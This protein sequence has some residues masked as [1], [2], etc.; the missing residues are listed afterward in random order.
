M[1][2]SSRYAATSSASLLDPAEQTHARRPGTQPPTTPDQALLQLRR[3]LVELDPRQAT[4][5]RKF[6]GVIPFGD[7]VADYLRSFRAAQGRL[8]A[9]LLDLRHQQEQ[10]A[11][12]DVAANRHQ[13][14]LWSAMRRL[15][16]SIQFTQHLDA[17]L[18]AKVVEVEVA[19]PDRAT[20]LSQEV[21]PAA[22]GRHRYLLSQLTVCIMSYLTVGAI[23]ENN[24]ERA[25]GLDQAYAAT[26]ALL[27]SAMTLA[28]A[29]TGQRLV[30][31]EITAVDTTTTDPDRQPAELS[32]AFADSHATLDAIDA[33]ERAASEAMASTLD[34]LRGLVDQ[35][36]SVRQC[37]CDELR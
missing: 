21:L 37:G 27:R 23:M 26:V 13:Q 1:T 24:R 36:E 4:G 18:S 19:D 2:P 29:R 30:L 7:R 14:D 9:I 11:E 8:N 35:A 32:A 25:R 22:R 15:N 12:A 6:L 28:P 33:F 3:V 31:D 17:R 10:L 16:A 34:A 5:S 20:V